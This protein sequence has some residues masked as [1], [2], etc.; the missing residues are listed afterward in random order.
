MEQNI[1]QESTIFDD[2]KPVPEYYS[3]RAIYG[4][5]FFCGALFGSILMAV[6]QNRTPDKKGVQEVIAFG[7]LYTV[8]QI[9]AAQYTPPRAGS[10][11]NMLLGIV[12]GTILNRFFWNKYIGQDVVYTKRSIVAPIII[13]MVLIVLLVLAVLTVQ[14]V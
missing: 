1:P 4:F 11:F 8:F 13:A 5:S 2:L 3:Q 14:A 9:V 6:N 7:I 12:A 10:S